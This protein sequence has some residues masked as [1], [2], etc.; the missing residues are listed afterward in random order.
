MAIVSNRKKIRFALAGC[1]HIG[2][3]HLAILEAEPLA[4]IAAV[5]DID[6]DKC[7]RYSTQYH[8]PYFTDFTEMLKMTDVDVVS[9]C[10]PHHM[11]MP[12]AIEAANHGK[13]ILVEKPMALH[14]SDARSMVDAARRN[15]VELMV[16]MQNRYNVPVVLAKKAL[17]GGHLGKIY[18]TQCNVLWNRNKEYY[19][20]S[21]WRGKKELEGGALYTQASHFVDLLVWFFGGVETSLVDIDTK[22]HPVNIEDCGT[23]IMRFEKGVMGT[24]SWTTC[25][26]HTNY[27]GSITII[28]DQGT[29]KIGGKYLNTIEYW[30]VSSYPLPENVSFT[31]TPNHYG[32]YQ[33]SSSNHDKVIEDVIAYLM[34]EKR[35]VVNEDE[36]IRSVEAIEKIYASAHL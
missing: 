21:D 11:H 13:H 1:G 17:D 31:D 30:D 26:Y 25:V 6:L 18:M 8:V 15:R 12:M 29:I 23:A 14:S 9:I 20:G 22:K 10:T 7:K 33:G 28:G 27:E 3:R 34:G 2:P 5:C 36:A 24:L 19:L 16:V 4:E 35:G 32:S